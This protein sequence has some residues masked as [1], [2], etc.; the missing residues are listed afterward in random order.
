MSA[1][2]V[3]HIID[4]LGLGGAQRL[5]VDLALRQRRRGQ[6]VAVVCL[7]AWTPLAAALAAADVAVHCLGRPKWSPRQI[8][9]LVPLLRSLR[10]Q[11]AHLHLMGAHTLGRFAAV[12]AGLPAV[13]VHDHEASAE[14]YTHPGPLLAAR[15][16]CE[17]AAPPHNSHYIVV[18]HEAASY[19]HQVR[20][21][22]AERTHV[23]PNGVDVE[24]LDACALSQQ[25][26]R[27]Q[28]GLPQHVPLA[29]SVG[30][31]SPVKGFDIL[32]TALAQLPGTQLAIA[33]DGPQR[34]SL[35]AQATALGLN[36][37]VHL[38]GQLADVRPLLR[39][40][41]LYVQPSRREAFG[42]GA[43]EAA[44]SGVPLVASAVGGLRELLRDGETGL[45]VPPEQPVALANA[46]NIL[47]SDPS[48]GQRMGAAASVEVRRRF[49]I[50]TVVNQIECVYQQ[51]LITSPTCPTTTFGATNR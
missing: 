43:V 17:A 36:E 20:R 46:L 9:D 44:A 50:E 38:L 12:L 49:S 31:L 30:R 27:H 11:L 45:L 23:V 21:W 1:P 8:L 18:S 37:R 5:V 7:R 16:L 40:G 28:L 32:L 13:V 14:I 41:D 26:A 34:A 3:V 4:H 35:H 39:A 15:R 29:V 24:H 48:L 10:P 2:H 42:L 25:A 6:Q 51:L 33:G 22:P 19:A 47:L